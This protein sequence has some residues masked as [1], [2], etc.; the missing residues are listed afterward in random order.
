[1]EMVGRDLVLKKGL[2]TVGTQ[3]SRTEVN[4]GGQVTAAPL[5]LGW[6][7]IYSPTL[8]SSMFCGRWGGGFEQP[9]EKIVQYRQYPP[10]FTLKTLYKQK[11]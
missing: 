8:K 2:A 4:V 1:M 10:I 6:A 5:S 7:R 3:E 11:I 9:Q